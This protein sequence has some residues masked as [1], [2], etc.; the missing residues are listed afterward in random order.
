V[1]TEV[2]AIEMDVPRDR[3]G[4]HEPKIVRKGQRR[5]EGIDKIAIGLYASGITARDIKAHLSEVYDVDVS[6][7]LTSKITDAV[8]DEVKEWQSR[9]LDP[10][11]ILEI[12]ANQVVRHSYCC[13]A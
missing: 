5:L 4:T 2:G 10:G 3:N 11:R 7:D 8:L 12:V 6:P 13:M 1:L 9:P